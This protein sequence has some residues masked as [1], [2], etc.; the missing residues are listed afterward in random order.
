MEPKRVVIDTNCLLQMLG[1]HSEYH[2]LWRAFIEERFV[3][4]F[5]SYK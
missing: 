5:V 2:A 4:C 1:K 3:L